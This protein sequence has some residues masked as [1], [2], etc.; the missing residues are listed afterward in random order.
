VVLVWLIKV[1]ERTLR[2]HL[3]WQERG[4]VVVDNDWVG[5]P[6]ECE[7]ASVVLDLEIDVQ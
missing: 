6:F 1:L 5:R 7:I 2:L 3:C 4:T